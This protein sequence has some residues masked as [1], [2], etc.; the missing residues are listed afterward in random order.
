MLPQTPFFFMVGGTRR[1]G[2]QII[3]ILRG[4]LS[5]CNAHMLEDKI[6]LNALIR[7]TSI[8]VTGLSLEAS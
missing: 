4:A 3:C 2:Y 5:L 8:L 7:R 6:Y 1:R